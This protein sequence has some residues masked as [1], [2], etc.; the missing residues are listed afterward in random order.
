LPRDGLYFADGQIREEVFEIGSFLQSRMAS[1]GVVCSDCHDPHTA[2]LKA[3][4]NAL[5]VQCHAAETFD[6]AKHHF[7]PAGTPGAQC[8]PGH[9]PTRT[10]MVVDVRRDHGLAIPRPDLSDRLGTPNPCVQCHPGRSNAWAAAVVARAT[11][12]RPGGRARPLTL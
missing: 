5:C 6:T 10:Y 8:V 3:E 2:R 9:M 12:D 4:G 7:H 11:A 1:K